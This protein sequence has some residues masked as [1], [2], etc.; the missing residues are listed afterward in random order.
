MQD[1]KLRTAVI[2]S[3]K[4]GAIH[5][6]VYDQLPQSELVAIVDV[7]IAKAKNIAIR[8][9]FDNSISNMGLENYGLS[10][11]DG[12]SHFEQLACLERNG[13]IG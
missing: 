6:K 4:M 12:V 11:F 5:A 1:A 10:L 9:F 7:D 2:G 3:G 13:V 8:P